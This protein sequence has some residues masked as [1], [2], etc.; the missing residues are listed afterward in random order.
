VVRKGPNADPGQR[1]SMLVVAIF[2]EQSARATQRT[3]RRLVD[4]L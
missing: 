3:R 4:H 2:F 1:R